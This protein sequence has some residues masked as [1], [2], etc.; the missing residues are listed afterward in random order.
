MTTTI[1]EV[2][3]LPNAGARATTLVRMNPKLFFE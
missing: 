3:K 1:H 2:E